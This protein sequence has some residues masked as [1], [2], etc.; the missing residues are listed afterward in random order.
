MVQPPHTCAM[1]VNEGCLTTGCS[2]AD[3]RFSGLFDG[4]TISVCA[5]TGL[6]RSRTYN[7]LYLPQSLDGRPSPERSHCFPV[8]RFCSR[9]GVRTA[10]RREPVRVPHSLSSDTLARSRS[11]WPAQRPLAAAI[12]SGERHNSRC[13]GNARHSLRAQSRGARAAPATQVSGHH[14]AR[15]PEAS[16]L[17]SGNDQASRLPRMTNAERERRIDGLLEEGWHRARFRGSHEPG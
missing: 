14:H 15:P 11:S 8:H 17:P 1:C 16:A 4:Q 12:D 2:G 9:L 5:P 3:E 13:M 6:G 10:H 7:S